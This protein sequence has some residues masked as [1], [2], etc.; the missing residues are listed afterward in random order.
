MFWKEKKKDLGAFW[1]MGKIGG[2]FGKR[3]KTKKRGRKSEGR[4][5]GKWRGRKKGFGYKQE[6][7]RMKE[8]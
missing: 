1:K 2:R 5:E 8:E 3:R 7:L 6:R 4:K